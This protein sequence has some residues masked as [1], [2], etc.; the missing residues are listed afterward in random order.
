MKTRM[1][2]G[3]AFC[4]VLLALWLALL[5]T[6]AQASPPAE[7]IVCADPATRAGW[8]SEQAIRKVFADQQYATAKLKVSRGGCYEFYAVQHDGSIVEAYYHPISGERVRY[9]KVRNQAN[10][11]AYETK[12]AGK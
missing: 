1:S 6:T 9:N 11:V 2:N 5:T 12:A 7:K 8:M 4:G 10:N 3:K